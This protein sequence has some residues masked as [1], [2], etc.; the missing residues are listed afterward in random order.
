MTHSSLET[1]HVVSHVPLHLLPLEADDT[2]LGS[3]GVNYRLLVVLGP[4][5]RSLGDKVPPKSAVEVVVVQLGKG[6][7]GQLALEL[8]GIVLVGVG[9]IDKVDVSPIGSGL[10]R[11]GIGARCCSPP[12]TAARAL[13]DVLLVRRQPGH[14][15]EYWYSTSTA[16]VLR[17]VLVQILV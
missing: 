17:T 14:G 8:D 2:V 3:H 6:P 12:D 13:L 1:D 9:L 10:G 7:G 5:G 15:W 4:M 11:R 16:R